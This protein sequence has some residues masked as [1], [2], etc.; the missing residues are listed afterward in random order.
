MVPRR[1]VQIVGDGINGRWLTWRW[2][3][4]AFEG[5]IHRTHD[6]D[7]WTRRLSAAL[8]RA[9]AGAG[10]PAG[11]RLVGALI[12]PTA[13]IELMLGLAGALLP[14]RLRE[15][16]LACHRDRVAVDVRVAP[17]PSAAAVPWGLLPLDEEL[18]L[19][20]V[21]NVSWIGPILPRDLGEHV[22]PVEEEAAGRPVLYVLDPVTS[23]GS[24]LG[25][26]ALPRHLQGNPQNLIHQQR[27]TRRDLSRD[28]QQRPARL[29]LL[30]HCV[31][32][33]T[34][35]DTGFV[36]SD[37]LQ[38]FSAA[39]LLRGSI[40]G[41]DERKP[42]ADCW[43]MPRHVAVVACASGID[44]ADHEPFGFATA[45]LVNGADTVHAT[46]WTLPTDHTL[47]R[48]DPAAGQAFTRLALAVDAA[49]AAA[50]PI[51]ALCDWQRTQLTGWRA[52]PCL[53]NAPIIWA[54]A[55]TITAP[56]RN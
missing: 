6:L 24:V 18:R 17:S 43:P 1:T 4:R 19:L 2:A 5:G 54:S 42:G 35:G 16:L 11:V 22:A 8:P 7:E 41:G 25:S 36:L 29:Y 48:H 30:G 32:T 52:N 9:S 39:D 56:R 38:P 31:R 15:Q 44:M 49:Q 55:M 13:E 33:G 46:L 12:D 28:L 40:N 34:A 3:G 53:D 21:A 14:V 47:G 20:D 26:S 50:D 51:G 27:Y 23:G 45:L 37:P 10:E